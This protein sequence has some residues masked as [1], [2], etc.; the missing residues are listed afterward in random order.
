MALQ[1][2]AGKMSMNNEK[3][4]RT[5]ERGRPQYVDFRE[6]SWTLADRPAAIKRAERQS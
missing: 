6:A 4:Q 5:T 3:N 2:L 1:A